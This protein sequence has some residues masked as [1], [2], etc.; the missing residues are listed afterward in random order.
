MSKKRKKK[1]SNFRISTKVMYALQKRDSSKIYCISLGGTS[2]EKQLV[3][4]SNFGSDIQNC[5][6]QY[7]KLSF[8]AGV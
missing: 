8:D 4:T 2:H 6:L 7:K 1:K 3:F 5:S